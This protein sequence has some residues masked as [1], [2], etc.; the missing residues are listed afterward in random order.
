MIDDFAE[1]RSRIAMVQDFSQRNRARTKPVSDATCP[2][3]PLRGLS[4][5]VIEDGSDDVDC[6]EEDESYDGGND[7]GGRL[8][9]QSDL[10]D[11][12]IGEDDDHDVNQP[13]ENEENESAGVA[14]VVA[15][16]ETGK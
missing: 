3:P 15:E 4:C 16:A 2:V 8:G 5:E 14:E 1:E 7:Y 11:G 9:V 13:R 10:L 12:L 6:R